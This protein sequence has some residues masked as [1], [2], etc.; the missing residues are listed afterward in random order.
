MFFHIVLFKIKPSVSEEEIDNFFIGLDS[1][2]SIRGIVSV[3]YGAIDKNVYKNFS[4]RTR[5]YTYSLVVKLKNQAFLESYEKDTYHNLVRTSVI[6][7]LLDQSVETPVM[8]VDWNDI[9]DEKASTM[10]PILRNVLTFGTILS[11]GLF[12]GW[13]FRS[14]Y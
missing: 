6:V 12:L 13:K 3:H 8:A 14:R 5:G 11:F 4:D 2:K 7:P 10:R 1:L 9:S